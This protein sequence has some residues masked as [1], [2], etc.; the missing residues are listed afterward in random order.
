[1]AS[2]RLSMLPSGF[3]AVLTLPAYAIGSAAILVVA[4]VL[5][6]GA[7]RLRGAL[8][9]DWVGLPARLAEAVLVVAT[10]LL[11]AEALGAVGLALA[12]A[13]LGRLADLRSGADGDR[14]CPAPTASR[15]VQL[16]FKPAPA[17]PAPEVG[18]KLERGAATVVVVAV[19]TQWITHV[20]DAYSRGM[21]H[22]DTLWYHAPF[23]ARFLQTGDFGELTG[24]G[25][26]QARW[27]PMAS[28]LV[29][30]LAA[31]PYQR[32]LLSPLVSV[33]FA[34]LA[35]LAAAVLGRRHGVSALAVCGTAVVL[36]LPSLAGT[37][38]GQAS[39]DVMAVAFVMASAALL[40][41]GRMASVP[42]CVAGLALGIAL[43]TKLTVAAVS[44]TLVVLVAI[45]AW[46][47]SGRAA[48]AA[49]VGAVAT[50]GAFW[51]LRNWVLVDN[52][53]PFMEVNLGPIQLPAAVDA[54]PGSSLLSDGS[55]LWTNPDWYLEGLARGYGRLWPDPPRH[56]GCRDRGRDRPR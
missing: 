41:E 38:P 7:V 45:V 11:V 39:N 31:M 46:R 49:W 53:W 56:R 18:S 33:G 1:M 51:F 28:E 36:G 54:P 22:P 55:R 5:V 14:A 17:K 20:I 42:T 21:V 19:G 9:T 12:A 40:V 35:L 15:L 3:L 10:C 47:H 26:D 2:R 6:G 32:D 23:T 48:A 4:L 37:Q 25:Y 24:L 13:D 34:C 27:F 50:G 29:H 44:G 52:P 43:A 30:A 16:T 8:L